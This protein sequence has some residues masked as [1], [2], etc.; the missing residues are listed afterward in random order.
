MED[1]REEGSVGHPESD[2]AEIPRGY[3]RGVYLTTA[4]RGMRDIGLHLLRV[5]CAEASVPIG[6][7]MY[8]DKTGLTHAGRFARTL[9]IGVN[10][11]S[12]QPCCNRD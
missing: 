10:A 1:D 12:T 6:G 9:C 7:H 8:G 4:C 5:K 3:A 11:I 2:V